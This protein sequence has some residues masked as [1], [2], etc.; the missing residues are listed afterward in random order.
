MKL[1]LDDVERIWRV[2]VEEVGVAENT[3]NKANFSR[4]FRHDPN[5]D[6]LVW[7][8]QGFIT[9]PTYA[10]RLYYD[11]TEPPSVSCN[12]DGLP[13]EGYLRLAVIN[14]KLADMMI[15]RLARPTHA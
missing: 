5:P 1:T 10:T 12:F 13:P 11:G 6:P 3:H 7:A 2:L 8:F 4:Y 15:G 14:A 9:Y